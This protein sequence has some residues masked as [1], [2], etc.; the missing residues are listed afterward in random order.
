MRKMRGAAFAFAFLCHVLSAADIWVAPDGAD[1]NAGTKEHPLATPARALRQARELRRLKDPSV[2][3]GVQIVLRGGEYALSEPLFIRPEDSGTAASPTVVKAAAGEQPVLSGGV[4]ITGWR[5]LTEDVANLPVTARGQAWVADIPRFNG[6]PLEF[7]QLWVD[8]SKA[9]RARTPGD[10]KM[11]R[12]VKWDRTNREAWIPA[13]A[14]MPAKL[15]GVELVLLQMWEIAVLRVKSYQAEGDRARVTFQDPESRVEFEHPWP[16]P[17]FSG[18]YGNSP[19]FLTNA[20]EFLD[21]PGEWF[22]DLAAGKIYYWPREG[23][24]LARARVVA[25]ALETLVQIA[26]T[27]DRPVINVS[28]E[29]ITFAYSTWLRPSTHGHVPLQA[30]MYLI[31]AYG[32]KPKGT[33]DWHGLDNQAWTGQPPAAITAAGAQHL[34]FF[35]C[36]VEHTAA[37][38]LDLAAAVSDSAVEGT[39]FH[40][41]GINGLMA[42]SFGDTGFEAHLPWNPADER[43]ICARLRLANNVLTDCANEDWGG[44]AL[45]AGFIR[46]TTIEHNE[47]SQTSYT[48][49]SLGWGWTRTPNATRRNVV[50]ANLIHHVATRMSDTDGIYALSAQAETTISENVVH[51]ITMSPYVHDPEHW[52]YLYADEGSSFSTW[53][54]NWCPEKK[55]LQN[56]NGPGNVWENNGPEVDAKI[57]A[58]AGL[59]PAFRDLL[60]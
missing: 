8:G 23:E 4:S 60:K 28:I 56:A 2:A 31:D 1:T 44:V 15:D 45:A 39:V 33:P 54:D 30:G 55:F 58:A 57:K 7:R 37:N 25:P 6:R 26:G 13:T 5:K 29:G 59:E 36:R 32:L 34:R 20:L 16:Q 35:R 19:F 17:V 11:E 38:G 53:K 42:G 9:V 22:E 51:S 21:E 14:V 47:I 12:L 24:D 40:D 52:F 48:G 50:H 43:V 10:G 41:I 18:K 46:D 3:E 49:I 27:P